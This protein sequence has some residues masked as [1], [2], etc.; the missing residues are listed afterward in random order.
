[1]YDAAPQQRLHLAD[2][3]GTAVTLLAEA[4]CTVPEIVSI[5]GHTMKSANVILEKY[6]A[7]TQAISDAAMFKFENA[8]VTNFANQLR[9][10]GA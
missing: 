2:L 8:E 4:G 9:T 10:A 7:R 1:M 3:R 5:T 6:L